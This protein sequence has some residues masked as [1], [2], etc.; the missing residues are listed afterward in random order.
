MDMVKQSNSAID[1]TP[2]G[3]LIEVDRDDARKL[4]PPSNMAYC[5]TKKS[6]NHSSTA[7]QRQYAD[8]KHSTSLLISD[9]AQL[10]HLQIQSQKSLSEN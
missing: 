5:N 6:L 2:L 7:P 3:T 10:R 1:I 4:K 8:F 9:N